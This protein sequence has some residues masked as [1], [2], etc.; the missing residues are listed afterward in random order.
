MCN[1]MTREHDTLSNDVDE[2]T[3]KLENLNPDL[4]NT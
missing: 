2:V 4:R 3:S 1:Q